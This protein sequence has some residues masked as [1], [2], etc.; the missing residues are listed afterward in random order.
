M[1]GGN[2]RN[3]I[4]KMLAVVNLGVGNRS[5]YFHFVYL[6][7]FEFAKMERQILPAHV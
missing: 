4:A 2:N 7:F 5:R 1:Y 3:Q 6:V